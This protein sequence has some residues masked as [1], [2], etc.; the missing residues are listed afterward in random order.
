MD[1][2]SYSF[3]RFTSSDQEFKDQ[4]ITNQEIIHQKMEKKM[5]AQARSQL[6]EIAN[7]KL[8]TS[9]LGTYTTFVLD[10]LY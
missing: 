3:K 4:G 10:V 1:N 7:Y 8:R 2:K 6:G 5:L 9:W